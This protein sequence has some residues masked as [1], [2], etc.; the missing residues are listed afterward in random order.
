MHVARVADQGRLAKNQNEVVTAQPRTSVQQPP[1]V[2]PRNG[3]K[4][5]HGVDGGRPPREMRAND[6]TSRTESGTRHP[7]AWSVPAGPGS[8]L[9]S[10]YS[11]DS[12]SDSSSSSS[13][14]DLSAILL[15]EVSMMLTFRP[16][17]NSS[18]RH[19]GILVGE[20]CQHSVPGGWS[21]R[22]RTQEIKLKLPEAARD[23]FNQLPKSI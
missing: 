10:S 13:D 9:S 16:Y 21:R 23:W 19:Q 8:S 18:I 3:V 11:V 5:H 17:V 7:G 1:R 2:K 22:V 15:K 14:D 20:V 6:S 4:E 12:D